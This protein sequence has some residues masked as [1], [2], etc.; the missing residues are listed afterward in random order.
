MSRISSRSMAI[1]C[2]NT[3]R[4]LLAARYPEA[5]IESASA[6]AP[7]M[8]ATTTVWLAISRLPWAPI[9]PATRP[10]LAV[11]PSLNP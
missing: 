4:S 11:S 2:S 5:P 9:M 1:S 6:I 8:P 7:A 3:S 10:K